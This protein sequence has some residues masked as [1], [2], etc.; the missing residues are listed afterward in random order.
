VTVVR[1]GG[2]VQVITSS[3]EGTFYANAYVE[4][5]ADGCD[6]TVHL[7]GEQC[8]LSG[9]SYGYTAMSEDDSVV[10][11]LGGSLR[12]KD[13]ASDYSSTNLR[14]G[15]TITLPEGA[16]LTSWYWNWGTDESN[17]SGYVEG[18]NKVDDETITTNLVITDIPSASYDTTI[19]SQ[20]VVVY[21]LDGVTYMVTD[22]VQSRSVNEVAT[23]IL[24][25]SDATAEE[26]TY[27]NGILGV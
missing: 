2:F 23:A 25:S 1:T 21:E 24:S 5:Y 22:S 7:T 13:S 18:V 27:A 16:E 4:E 15:Y 6:V 10:S 12:M 11:F 20:L 8:E 17:L 9:I 14:F 19:Y 26:I 3:D